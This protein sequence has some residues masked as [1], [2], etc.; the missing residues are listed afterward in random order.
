ML[1]QVV[2]VKFLLELSLL[3]SKGIGSTYLQ[4]LFGFV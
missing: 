3:L 2:G 4:L 1:N